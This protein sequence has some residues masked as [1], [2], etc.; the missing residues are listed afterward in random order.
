M[1]VC[2]L[3]RRAVLFPTPD[4]AGHSVT[5]EILAGRAEPPPVAP[6]LPLRSVV[7]RPHQ[8]QN[9]QPLSRARQALASLIRQAQ[10]ARADRAR[11]SGSPSVL[12]L[13]DSSRVPGAV[14]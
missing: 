13:R 3:P 2:T 1:P 10:S 8:S 12:L 4:A 6:L 11:R 14:P 9:S 5:S 7:I